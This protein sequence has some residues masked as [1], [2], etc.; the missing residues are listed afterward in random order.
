MIKTFIKKWWILNRLHHFQIKSKVSTYGVVEISWF[1][2]WLKSGQNF[3]IGESDYKE[4]KEKTPFCR[5]LMFWWLFDAKNIQIGA[6]F[7][8]EL[9][10]EITDVIDDCK[11]EGLIKKESGTL[12]NIGLDAEGRKVYSIS[13]LIFYA[14]TNISRIWIIIIAISTFILGINWHNIIDWWLKKH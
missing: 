9:S 4:G 2:L 12:G 8:D 13:Y 10:Q 14:L 7:E 1:I 6:F 3:V 11:K 5:R